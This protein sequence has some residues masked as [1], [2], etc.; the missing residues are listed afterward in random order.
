MKAVICGAGVAGLTLAA[1]LGRGGWD[2]VVLERECGPASGGYL[3]D[4]SG[5]GLVAADRLGLL[6]RLKEV[7]Q[8]VS[9]VR[10]VNERGRQIVDVDLGKQPRPY[11]RG[12]KILRGD[13]E[14]ILL[15]SL[16]PNVE[17]RFGFDVS[18]IRTPPD[19][20]EIGVRPSGHLAA[21]VLV[22]A[23]GVH[24]RIRD[25]VFGDGGLWSCALG[26][27][28]AAFSFRDEKIEAMLEGRY[29]V[30]SAPGRHVVVCP[31]RSG[32]IAAMFVHRSLGLTP[33]PDPLRTLQDMY[34]S[35]KWCVPRLLRH[36]RAAQE[37]RYEPAMQVNLTSWHRGRIGLL[38]DAC[39]AY[40]L[41]PGQS[42][43]VALASA[44]W[45]G[46]E[47]LRA[48]SVDVAFSW[49]QSRLSADIANRRA[50]TRRAAQWLVP[51]NSRDLALRNGLLR[52]SGIPGINRL[53]RSVVGGMA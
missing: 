52:L 29:T 51:S 43:S 49:Y 7:G 38:G 23:D 41:L 17:V 24:S 19:R 44:T 8:L 28:T 34:T 26:F 16:P 10:W 13:L 30:L 5:N 35:M 18:E 36:A 22:G 40:S 20:V 37:L 21:D 3:V 47:M 1:Q 48:P 9:T 33:P 31:L 25:L 12:W 42:A 50:R 32:R 14:R 11:V 27:D 15:E 39:H 4:I 2:V 6:P 53:V 45:L 46:T